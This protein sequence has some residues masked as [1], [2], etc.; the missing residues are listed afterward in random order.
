MRRSRRGEPEVERAFSL[1]KY[2]TEI[3]KV[4]SDMVVY[5]LKVL[6]S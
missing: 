6:Q 4:L 3:P 5:D 1:R 2:V